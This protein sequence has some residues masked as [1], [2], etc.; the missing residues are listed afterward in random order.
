MRL[1]RR[2]KFAALFYTFGYCNANLISPY[3][4]E[5][6]LVERGPG[7]ATLFLATHPHKY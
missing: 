5:K 3:R 7:V 1:E 6:V 4:I 2:L